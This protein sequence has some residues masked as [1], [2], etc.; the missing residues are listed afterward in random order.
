MQGMGYIIIIKSSLIS[1]LQIIY[2]HYFMITFLENVLIIFTI[3]LNN[4]YYLLFMSIIITFI[5]YTQ[6]KRV[7]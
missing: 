5:I 4:F 3:F 7:L 2:I 1:I 6:L